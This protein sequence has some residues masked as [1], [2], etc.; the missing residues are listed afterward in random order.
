MKVGVFSGLVLSSFL[1]ILP[2][3][4]NSQ[5]AQQKEIALTFDDE[6][7]PELFFGDNG[8]SKTLEANEAHAT[9]F[10][11]G[12][13]VQVHPALFRQLVSEGH[14]IENHTWGHENL[15]KL[16]K[17]KG[18]DSVLVTVEKTSREIEHVVGRRP[19]YFRP[20]YWAIDREL[21][22]LIESHGY[23]VMNIDSPDINTLDYDDNAHHRPASAL[24]N[25]V[26]GDIKKRESQNEFRHVL[27]FHET[28]QTRDALIEMLP[29]LRSQGYRFVTLEKFFE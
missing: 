23:R 26:L 19:R 24:I 14:E 20:P 8:I 28:P 3:S 6:I 2:V 9:F 12:C 11:L 15:L 29:E 13:Q 7:R 4:L 5:P 25:R 1:F 21:K 22:N 18:S 17:Q 10:A 16:N 27:V